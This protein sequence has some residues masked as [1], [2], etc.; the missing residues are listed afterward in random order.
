MDH[1]LIKTSHRGGS[2]SKEE[3]NSAILP[4]VRT[5]SSTFNHLLH[6]VEDCLEVYSVIT[7][8]QMFHHR[9]HC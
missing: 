7:E 3:G 8:N 5:V 4:L 6:M 1:C 2:K 9:D